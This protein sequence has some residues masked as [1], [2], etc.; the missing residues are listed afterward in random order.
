MAWSHVHVFNVEF[1]KHLNVE[2]ECICVCMHVCVCV[3]GEGRVAW[4][5]SIG[6]VFLSCYSPGQI[7]RK[8]ALAWPQGDDGFLELP[9]E[10]ERHTPPPPGRQGR[11]NLRPELGCSPA[12][13][14]KLIFWCI[15]HF[16]F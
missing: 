7:A 3:L 13:H 8:K 15:I 10:I 1:L 11:V 6:E 4:G 12:G 9:G 16:A 14:S 2:C 5:R